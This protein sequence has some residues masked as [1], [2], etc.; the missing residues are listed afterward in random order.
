MEAGEILD[1]RLEETL[2]SASSALR[3]WRAARGLRWVLDRRLTEGRS[4]AVVAFVFERDAHLSPDG[5]RC[6]GSAP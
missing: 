5:I 3:A 6:G 1:P 2:G 4:G